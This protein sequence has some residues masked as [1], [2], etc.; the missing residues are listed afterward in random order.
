[1][2]T[3]FYWHDD[4]L[5]CKNA[6]EHCANTSVIHVGKRSAGW[7]FGFRGWPHLLV[8]E[9]HP[10][11]GF[12]TESPFGFPVM[13]RSDWRKVFARPGRLVSEYGDE[14]IDPPVWLDLLV[15]PSLAEIR[16][17]NELSGGHVWHRDAEGFRVTTREFS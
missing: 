5:V 12:V 6:C 11:W 16:H 8:D 2:G 3:N 1:M 10:D 7:S 14:Q 9:E 13:S 15:P 17:E 4:A